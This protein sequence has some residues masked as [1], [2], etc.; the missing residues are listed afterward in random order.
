MMENE[1]ICRFIPQDNHPKE[2]SCVNFVYE[3]HP[4]FGGRSV[5]SAAYTVF[6]VCSGEGTLHTSRCAGKLHPGTLFFSFPALPYLIGDNGGL[7][8]F[9]ITFIG[10]RAEGLFALAGITRENCIRDGCGG[11]IAYWRDMLSNTPEANVGIAAEAVLLHTFSRLPPVSAPPSLSRGD[12]TVLALKKMAD[13]RYFDSTLSLSTAAEE[14]NYNPK[15]LSGLFSRQLGIGFCAYLHSV[16]MEHAREL[17]A[18]GIVSIREIARLVGYPDAAYFSRAFRETTGL[19][20][21]AYLRM[22]QGK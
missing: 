11:M 18:S 8:Y 16:R 4:D 3:T 21:R 1:N 2:L 12:E 9:Y 5:L 14:F 13:D 20:P 17:M 19:S 15:Y 7:S 10:S 6:L 22:I